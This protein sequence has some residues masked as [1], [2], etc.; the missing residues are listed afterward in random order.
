MGLIGSD[1]ASTYLLPSPAEHTVGPAVI[2]LL[3]EFSLSHEKT[4]AS[5]LTGLWPFWV[6]KNTWRQT[7]QGVWNA[8]YLVLVSVLEVA[9]LGISG[10]SREAPGPL[11]YLGW[12]WMKF[13][14]STIYDISTTCRHFLRHLAALWR[15]QTQS[16]N[17]SFSQRVRLDIIWGFFRTCHRWYP[18]RLLWIWRHFPIAEQTDGPYKENEWSFSPE[19]EPCVSTEH[20]FRVGSIGL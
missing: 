7:C 20:R 3:Y 5:F 19:K 18:H 13:I 16:L 15:K 2:V 9:R 1:T 14:H 4:S 6:W 17:F 11:R 10:G 12:F 8:M